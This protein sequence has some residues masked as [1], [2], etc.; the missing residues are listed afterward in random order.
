MMAMAYLKKITNRISAYFLWHFKWN[1]L[2][3]LISLA[4]AIIAFTAVIT[5]T[6]LINERFN[7]AT[8]YSTQQN[9][10]QIVDSVAASID[11]YLKEMISISDS[12]TDMLS[13]DKLLSSIQSEYF[14]L[15]EDIN[16]IAVC[17]AAAKIIAQ[18]E[19]TP[20]KDNS[21]LK[22]QGWFQ[23]IAKT[24]N[25]YSFTNP[26]VQRLYE[27]KYPW[28][29]S[30]CKSIYPQDADGTYDK[31]IVLVD[32]NFNNIKEMCSRE[33]GKAG[34]IYILGPENK[35]IYHPRQQMIYAGIV[36][37]DVPIEAVSEL[38]DGNTIILENGE[39]F[40]VNVRGLAN[41]DWRIIG[42]SPMKGFFSYDSELFN[43]VSV[44]VTVATFMVILIAALVSLFLTRP[45]R[46]LMGMMQ[47]VESGDFNKVYQMK[48]VY[49]VSALSHSF[50]Q[51]VHRIK[52]LMEELR[53]E[54]E[55]IRKE[56]EQL[57]KS[58]LKFL[59]SQLNPH[60]LY[61]TL[62]SVV[63]MAEA[64]DQKNV[65]KMIDALANFFRLTLSGGN[66]MIS[67]EN[68]LKHTENYL[69][70]QKM[71]YDEQFDYL[72]AYEPECEAYFT[73][74][75]VLQPIVENAIIH[76]FGN[77]PD[78]GHIKI[79]AYQNEN[80]LVF[81]VKDNGSGIKPE[82]LEN[83]L[84]AKTGSKSGVG[85]RNVNKRIQLMFGKDYGLRYES[86]RDV[87]T[88][89]YISLPLMKTAKRGDENESAR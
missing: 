41:A 26:H 27:G 50:S 60:F 48:G 65:I 18:T 66:D 78:G 83:I 87:G 56:Q 62:D 32:L 33:L 71:R 58:E 6:A 22:M 73:I 30:L 70:I 77:M 24:D 53:R 89:V 68:E 44:I 38:P 8:D 76:G 46:R 17:D 88:T 74:K 57:R 84:I 19:E 4:T 64:G 11:G 12:V 80:C 75:N 20:V 86:E 47:S 29:I 5:I 49:E 25:T 1:S 42:V 52:T 39:R 10:S 35:I 81:E 82:I 7:Q 2:W 54:Q 23:S 36:Q 63:W 72:I 16:T 31:K 67:V 45:L 55:Q 14:F 51:M 85:V 40:S 69:I 3:A 15:R 9:S 13:N 37:N 28:V 79:R 59:Q 43:F 21:P 61:N 34:Y